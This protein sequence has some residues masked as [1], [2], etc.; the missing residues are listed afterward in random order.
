MS[1]PVHIMGR[2]TYSLIANDKNMEA[3]VVSLEWVSRSY[4]QVTHERADLARVI[5]LNGQNT[6]V[7]REPDGSVESHGEPTIC[8]IPSSSC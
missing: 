2:R 3:L 8:G 6:K 7:T 4:R 1:A 5:V